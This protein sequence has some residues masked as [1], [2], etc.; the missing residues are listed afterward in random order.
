MAVT[1]QNPAPYATG[2]T[3]RD[4]MKRYRERG[5]TKPI[6]SDVLA[7]AGV[8]GSL[9]P[10]TVQSLVALELIN[11]EGMP[12]DTLEGIRLATATE[13]QQ[14]VQEWLKA[15]YAEVFA[16]VDPATD[17]ETAIRDAFRSYQP[18]GQQDRMVSL[19]LALCEEAGLRKPAQSE[20]APR[21]ATKKP[22]VRAAA[23]VR[24]QRQAKPADH[25]G[26][27]LATG[28]PAPLAGLLQSLPSGNLGWTKEVRDKFVATFQ[29]VLDYCVP[30][31]SAK[32]L[33]AIKNPKDEQHE[34]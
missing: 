30:I 14:R 31:R 16:F 5:M 6:N 2:S 24:S 11:D 19:F 21:T 4:L 28:L 26:T 23:S 34:D 10:R 12:T 15:V 20:Q 17:D 9:I 1:A 7:R 27:P 22:A 3:I 8:S 33:D 32:E 13:Y 18:V 29:S 25:L